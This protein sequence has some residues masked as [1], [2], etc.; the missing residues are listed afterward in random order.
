MRVRHGPPGDGHSQG[1]REF[2]GVS[3]ATACG[4]GRRDP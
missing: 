3:V 2:A 4:M 1:R